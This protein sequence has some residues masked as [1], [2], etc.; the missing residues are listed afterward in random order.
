MVRALLLTFIL[1]NTI[2]STTAQVAD[3]FANINDWQGD[4]SKFTTDN[5]L[6]RSNSNT[7]NDEFYISQGSNSDNRE[8]QLNI[9]LKFNTSSANYV[10]FVLAANNPNLWNADSSVYVRIGNTKDEISLYQ[11]FDGNRQFLIDG[12]DDVT[13]KSNNE[14]IV[15]ARLLNDSLF[16]DYAETWAAPTSFDKLQKIELSPSQ[17]KF[18]NNYTGFKIRQSTASFF[19]DHYIDY[20]Y[21][22]PT[23]RDTTKPQ[24]VSLEVLNG[25]QIGIKFTEEVESSTLAKTSN[26]LIAGNTCTSAFVNGADSVTIT[27]S[28]AF[29]SGTQQVLTI[30]SLIDLEGNISKSISAMFQF[31]DIRSAVYKDLFVTEIFSK[32]GTTG[33]QAEAIEI[34]NNT[35]FFIN[36]SNL[37]F[38]DL[39]GE[40]EFPAQI[41]SPKTYYVL[42][43]D[44]DTAFFDNPIPLR[45]MPTLN[46]SRDLILIEDNAQ[47]IIANVVYESSWHSPGKEDGFW[48][49]EMRDMEKGCYSQA[50]F[51]SS[52]N[53]NGHTLGFTNS[54]QNNL[55]RNKITLERVYANL[56]NQVEV[57]FSDALDYSIATDEML[58][59]FQPANTIDSVKLNFKNPQNVTLFLSN[60][61]AEIT[62]LTIAQQ[63]QCSGA[64]MEEQRIQ[65]GLANKPELGNL[66]ITELMFNAASNCSE[67]VEIQNLSPKFVDLRNAFMGHKSEGK[68][69]QFVLTADNY[70][71]KP[72]GLAVLV[73]DKESFLQ[74][75]SYCEGALII[76]VQDWTSLDDKSGSIWL[77]NSVDQVI[78]TIIYKEEYHSDLLNDEDGVALEKIDTSQS[79]LLSHVWAS[80]AENNNY[81]TPGCVNTYS[82]PSED[83]AIFSLSSPYFGNNF[84]PR[85]NIN[86]SFAKSNYQLSIYVMDR[87]GITVKQVA[88]NSIV[89]QEGSYF[90]D[91]TNE[92]GEVVAVGIYFI[93]A[94]ATHPDGEVESKVLECTKLE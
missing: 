49:L 15:R 83:K 59:S 22:G 66:Q 43:D 5:S 10:D 68:N 56:N 75:Y 46:D 12:V 70:M 17:L 60:S 37:T 81:A 69:V 93:K 91:G 31:Q 85:A 50:N 62:T 38:R 11:D 14:L 54:L 67:Y 13:K 73:Q 24:V 34:Y 77:K 48:S 9:N 45:S 52:V 88:N 58:Y 74:C 63:S 29:Q 28:N 61:M 39:T 80:S 78:D 55:Q 40:E 41:L 89:S 90:W 26:Y 8:W 72:Q 44:S 71:L 4:L 2:L 53:S 20:F 76:E 23:V 30:D 16:L 82:T 47:N 1:F 19:G 27:F 79:G 92:S 94:L 64:E 3:S 33:L 21:A 36:T 7:V 86:Y 25:T 84:N 65:I 87:K 6:L 32:T 35:D 18:I 51:S 57:Y 42:C